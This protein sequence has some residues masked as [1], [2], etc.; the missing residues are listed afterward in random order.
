M[1]TTI[2][3][4]ATIFSCWR[5]RN[6][7]CG[8]SNGRLSIFFPKSC[9]CCSI[10]R[11]N[12]CARDGGHRFPG[13]SRVPDTSPPAA[14]QR[15]PFPTEHAQHAYCL[16]TGEDTIAYNKATYRCLDRP[17]QPCGYISAAGGAAGQRCL[18]T[19]CDVR[20]RVL[21]G[22]SWNNDNT[23]N[24]RASNR[25]NNNPRNRNNNYGFR[26]VSRSPGPPIPIM[27]GSAGVASITVFASVRR[28][29]HVR[30]GPVPGFPRGRIANR[31]AATGRR[32]TVRRPSPG[33]RS[34]HSFAA[35]LRLSLAK[36]ANLPAGDS[37]ARRMRALP[38]SY[39]ILNTFFAF[40]DR[41]R[42]LSVAA[43]AESR[44]MPS[45]YTGLMSGIPEP[46]S[47]R[48]APTTATASASLS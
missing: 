37:W 2:C 9:G 42:S 39:G 15:V 34:L 45:E 19:G 33:M 25:N 23:G 43:M 3:A 30:R 22:G 24:L 16:S 5:R 40:R 4:T 29:V 47:K 38:V 21:R 7:H 35:I 1:Y 20:A 31:P 12:G 6:P 46:K 10:R 44:T 41:M 13:L 28:G 36:S 11:N 32:A 48:W 18:Q 17:C 14:R 27:S 8:A 26:C